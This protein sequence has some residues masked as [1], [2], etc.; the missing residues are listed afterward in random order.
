M[1]IT[2]NFFHG[3]TFHKCKCIKNTIQIML[4]CSLYYELT[5]D[6]CCSR[7]KLNTLLFFTWLI[8]RSGIQI[9]HLI[10]IIFREIINKDII[11]SAQQPLFYMIYDSYR[12]NNLK[13]QNI[14][15]LADFNAT[16]WSDDHI[17]LIHIILIF[18]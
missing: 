9:P 1:K 8:N 17:H 15:S 7:R 5:H 10:P 2:C 13:W 16:V 11:V 12:I 6:S 18:K 14:I 3:N 4:H